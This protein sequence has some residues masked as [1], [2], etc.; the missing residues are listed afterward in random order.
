MYGQLFG[1]FD[2][3]YSNYPVAITRIVRMLTAPPSRD[4]TEGSAAE[5]TGMGTEVMY[6]WSTLVVRMCFGSFIV[7]ILVGAFNKVCCLVR[8]AS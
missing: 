8:V 6:Y 5:A 1:V 4:G 3:G 7:A 2:P